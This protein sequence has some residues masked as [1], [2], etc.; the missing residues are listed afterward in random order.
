M[1]TKP[2][3]PS[4]DSAETLR[5]SITTNRRLYILFVGICLLTM[6]ATLSTSDADL[7]DLVGNGIT[8]PFA[9][10]TIPFLVLYTLV[11]PILITLQ[12]YLCFHLNQHKEKLEKNGREPS[13][14][15][16]FDFSI[17]LPEGKERL[18]AQR[19]NA[20]I[21]LTLP[22]LTILFLL[23]RIIDYQGALAC[24]MERCLF[25]ILSVYCIPLSQVAVF[26]LEGHIRM[27][28]FYITASYYT[29][30]TLNILLPPNLS[31]RLFCV[32]T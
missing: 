6:T 20:F 27:D 12:R 28:I 18:S 16:V 21:L 13:I 31:G 32:C 25:C 7:L 29:S 5:G 19:F 3:T 1:S 24:V 11:A 4:D 15:F 17:I 30:C 23:I 8:I 10:T 2:H 22:M 14:P 9:G 26:F